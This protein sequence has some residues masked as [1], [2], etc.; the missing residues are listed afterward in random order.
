VDEVK[1]GEKK[2]RRVSKNFRN[3]EKRKVDELE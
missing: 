1:K 2:G 3:R